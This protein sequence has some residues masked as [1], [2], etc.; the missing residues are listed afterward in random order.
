VQVVLNDL[1][2]GPQLRDLFPS[3]FARSFP[4]V[5]AGS[6]MLSAASVL[7]FHGIEAALVLSERLEAKRIEK[8]YLFMGGYAVLARLL[9]ARP[10]EYYNLLFEPCNKSAMA[11]DSITADRKLGDLLN[12]FRES[13]FGFTVLTEGR[14]CALIGL[15]DLIPLYEDG[16]I[17]TGLR[18]RDVASTKISVAKRTLIKDALALMFERRIRRL[19]IGGGGSYVSD[20]EIISH[21][22]SPQTLEETRKSPSAFLEGAI[23]DVGAVDAEEIRDGMS[24]ED[25]ADYMARSQGATLVCEKGVV[26]PWDLVMKPFVMKRL[27]VSQRRS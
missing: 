22:F 4:M 14:L 9:K 25:A 8:K 24:L 11:L 7:R 12:H 16:S 2:D 21:V 5:E 26:S 3:V 18:A 13:R 10:E 23:D 20:R 19:F 1:G 27:S 6:Y 17:R 15:S